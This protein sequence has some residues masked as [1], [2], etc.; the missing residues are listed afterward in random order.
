METT[1]YDAENGPLTI[2]YCS[3]LIAQGGGMDIFF[4]ANRR[5]KLFVLLLF[6]SKHS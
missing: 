6:F 2:P 1:R 3:F 5:T 4:F